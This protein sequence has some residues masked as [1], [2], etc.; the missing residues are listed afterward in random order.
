[1]FYDRFDVIASIGNKIKCVTEHKGKVYSCVAAII[2]DS[3]E[4]PTL[5]D[6][7]YIDIERW[8]NKEWFFCCLEVR[9]KKHGTAD[10]YDVGVL[11]GLEVNLNGNDELTAYAN[12]LLNENLIFFAKN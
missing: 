1:M 10:V 7:S 3:D 6:Y 11:F 8:K 2:E 9:S 4:I 12:N 5:R